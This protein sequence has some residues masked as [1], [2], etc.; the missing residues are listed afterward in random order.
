MCNF[1]RVKKFSKEYISKFEQKR[2][3]KFYSLYERSKQLDDYIA[4]DAKSL[5]KTS[6]ENGFYSRVLKWTALILKV[7]G[8]YV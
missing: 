7:L 6:D 5:L 8:R 2:H 3:F 1:Q 4:L